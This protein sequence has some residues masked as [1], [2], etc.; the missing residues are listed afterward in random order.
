MI[1]HELKIIFVHIPRTGGSSV[2]AALAG[3][4]WWL[5]SPETKHLDWQQAR[6][7][8]REYWDD[9]LKFTIVRNSWD[10]M[11]SLFNSHE[12]GLSSTWKEFLMNPVL[13][14]H[15]Q[16]AVSQSEIVGEEL[17]LILRFEHIEEDFLKLCSLIGI[18]RS[19]PE[20]EVG[21]RLKSH[22]SDYFSDE[23][24]GICAAVNAEDINRFGFS[25]E[26]KSADLRFK[27]QFIENLNSEMQRL[28]AL[29]N[30]LE[31]EKLIRD[32]RVEELER[33]IEKLER[34]SP[35]VMYK[36]LKSRFLG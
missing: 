29:A 13:A 33:Y 18:E 20:E 32:Q 31:A 17:D 19:L 22:Y 27:N 16:K 28:R 21:K 5:V 35:Y 30:K 15:E 9:Y 3:K 23:E 1:S 25:F 7:L 26:D 36:E 34:Y 6:A 12:R 11:V 8:Y 24:K 2:E 10:W 14:L 4:D